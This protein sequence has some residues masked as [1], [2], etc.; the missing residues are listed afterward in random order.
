MNTFPISKQN[1]K[2]NVQSVVKILL[3]TKIFTFGILSLNPFVCS[4]HRPNKPNMEVWS[5]ESFI[6]KRTGDSCSKD[7]NSPWVPENKFL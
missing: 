6:A 5:R 1:R 2:T 4:E 3:I 7:P